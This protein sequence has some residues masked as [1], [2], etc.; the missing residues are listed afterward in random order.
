V[1][2][3]STSTSITCVPSSVAVGTSTSCLATVT[4]GYSPSG[5]V[6]FVSTSGSGTFTPAN[7]CTLSSGTCQVSYFDSLQG[8]PQ[9]IGVYGGDSDNG[10]SQGS[11]LLVIGSPKSSTSSSASVASSSTSTTGGGGGAIPEFPTSLAAVAVSAVLVLV[12]YAAVRHRSERG[13]APV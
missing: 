10:G 6:I 9:I 11:A 5:S 12:A 3:A 2:R 7:N 1:V 8:T 4:G 13:P